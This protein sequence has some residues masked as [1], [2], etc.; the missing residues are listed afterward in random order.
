MPIPYHKLQK[1]DFVKEKGGGDVM[2]WDSLYNYDYCIC[3][4]W[5][6]LHTAA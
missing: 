4:V 1:I 2:D 3:V 6:L 5:L